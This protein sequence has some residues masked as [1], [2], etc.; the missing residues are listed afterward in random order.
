MAEKPIAELE[1]ILHGYPALFW[2]HCPDSRGCHGRPGLPDFIVA[3]PGGLLGAEAKPPGDH[4][5]G[6]QV[7]WRYALLAGGTPYVVWT[8]QDIASGRVRAELE[9]LL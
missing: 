6:G 1:A 9:A 2:H 7:A 5:R 8:A 3:G 4:P